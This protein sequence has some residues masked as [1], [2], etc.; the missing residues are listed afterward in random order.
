M[1]IFYTIISTICSGLQPIVKKWRGTR[2]KKFEPT[3][4]P[5]VG[6]SQKKEEDESQVSILTYLK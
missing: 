2:Y 3:L 5:E 4:F 6:L 1:F